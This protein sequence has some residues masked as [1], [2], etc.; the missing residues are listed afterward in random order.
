MEEIRWLVPPVCPK[1]GGPSQKA[2]THCPYC[3]SFIAIDTF[4]S[5]THS[6]FTPYVRYQEEG[7]SSPSLSPSPEQYASPSPSPEPDEEYGY[8]QREEV[9]KEVIVDYHETVEKEKGNFAR[10]ILRKL[11]YD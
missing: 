10:R 1:C 5:K 7:Y 3:G 9:F 11:G 6:P 8:E 4:T 2:R